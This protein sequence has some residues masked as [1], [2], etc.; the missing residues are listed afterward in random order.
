MSTYNKSYYLSNRL[1]MTERIRKYYYD[2]KIEF[3]QYKKKYYE[4]NKQNTIKQ[5]KEYY[6]NNK[7]NIV[8][9]KFNYYYKKN[10]DI[11]DDMICKL[12]ELKKNLNIGKFKNVNYYITLIK[13]YNI[14]INWKKFKII[15]IL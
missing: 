1:K 5:V 11:S 15:I 3:A 7:K 6:K 4:I 8:E 10:Y 13:L 12:M 9:Y 14:E 2:N